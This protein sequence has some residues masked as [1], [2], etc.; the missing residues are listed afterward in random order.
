MGLEHD[1][2]CTPFCTT[3]V[4]IDFGIKPANQKKR[5]YYLNKK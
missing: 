1:H 3:T 4:E 2:Y 5:V